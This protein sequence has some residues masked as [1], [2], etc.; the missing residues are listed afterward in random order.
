MHFKFRQILLSK[1][2]QSS[3]D[4][5]Y[6]EKDN[7]KENCYT[8]IIIDGRKCTEIVDNTMNSINTLGRCITLY[9]HAHCEGRW[10]VVQPGSQSHNNLKD[11]G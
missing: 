5:I 3:K 7:F 4:F 9:D 6:R 11:F 10:I 8:Q 1:K 2:I